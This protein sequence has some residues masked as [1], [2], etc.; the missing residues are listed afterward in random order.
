M[1]K[2]KPCTVALLRPPETSLIL[3]ETQNFED[4][5]PEYSGW[6][7]DWIDDYR[8][9]IQEVAENEKTNVSVSEH[10]LF[11]EI[12]GKARR[13]FIMENDI[14]TTIDPSDM[15]WGLVSGHIRNNPIGRAILAFS[16]REEFE[17]SLQFIGAMRTKCFTETLSKTRDGMRAVLM[18]G[19]IPRCF[20]FWYKDNEQMQNAVGQALVFPNGPIITSTNIL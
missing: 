10:Q 4:D 16:S 3:S 8:E 13:K 19:V 2:N 7:E 14:I 20:A 17:D 1:T 5:E 18:N 9:D 11:N 6:I 12:P 15:T